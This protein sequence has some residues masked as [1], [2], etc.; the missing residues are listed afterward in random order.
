VLIMRK[1]IHNYKVGP[2]RVTA[3]CDIDLTVEAG[4]F[5]AVMGPSGSGKS[6]IVNAAAG[7]LDVTAGSIVVDGTEIATARPGARARLR[8]D[9][10]GVVHQEDELDPLLSATE[11]VALPLLLG[12]ARRAEAHRAA[13]AALERCMVSAVGDRTRDQLSGGQRQRVAVARAIVGER[14]VVLADEPTAALDT[15]TAR[16][17]VETLASLAADGVAVLMTTHDS[18]LATYADRVVLLR[19]GRWVEPAV[20]PDVD[21]R[22]LEVPT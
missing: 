3:L 12:G 13:L 21:A 1:V 16:S 5:V 7:L 22:T 11:N 6:T 18:R 15:A 8:R 10:I 14:R 19:D 4:E 17:L 2:G 20:G 9:V